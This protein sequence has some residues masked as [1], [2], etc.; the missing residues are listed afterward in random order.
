MEIITKEIKT[1]YF[2]N[3]I[4]DEY[5]KGRSFCTYDIETLGLDPRRA[6]VILAGMMCVSPDGTAE[7]KQFFLEEPEEEHILLD[8]I[9]EE[10][11][12]YDYIVTYNGHR[13]DIPY[14]EKR[15]RMIY[16]KLPDIRPFDLDL[17]LLIKSHSGLKSVLPSL[18]QKSVEQYMGLSDS[19]DDQ[20]SGGE[21][22]QL[23]YQYLLEEDTS[24][25]ESIKRTILL[26][27]FDDVVQLYRLL[28][29]IKQ[30]DLHGAAFK[31]GFPV[32][33]S[34]DPAGMVLKVSG[35][36]LTRTLLT[37]TGNY[38]GDIFSYKSFS[39]MDQI[40][41]AEFD[42]DRTFKVTCPVSAG[43][44][45]LFINLLDFFAETDDF[46]D[47]RGFVNNYLIL[48]NEKELYQRDINHFVRRLLEKL[49]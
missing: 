6:P 34:S 45:A 40:W 26:H 18:R 38:S 27:N 25:K 28:P 30:C 29:I 33:E 48:K 3:H 8:R 1:E 36:K 49:L 23:Y 43:S 41:E 22:V 2:S 4:M 47:Y 21:S 31:L 11:N 20:I 46:R 32:Y 10:L 7:V 14:V 17:Y 15:Y 9:L 5:F 13:F 16:H 35:I 12:K 44:N 24:V 19:R 39:D 42:R 37:V